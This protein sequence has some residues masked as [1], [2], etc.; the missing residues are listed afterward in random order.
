[1]GHYTHYWL[2]VL[3]LGFYLISWAAWNAEDR[4]ARALRRGVWIGCLVSLATTLHFQWLVH[5]YGGLPGE[6]S[7]AYRAQTAALGAEP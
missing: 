1:M 3:P 5:R 7:T 4:R 6:Y 2:P